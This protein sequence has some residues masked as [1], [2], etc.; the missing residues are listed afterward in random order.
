M[1]DQLLASTQNPVALDSLQKA[2]ASLQGKAV[3][4]TIPND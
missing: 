2:R 3:A 1:V 4:A